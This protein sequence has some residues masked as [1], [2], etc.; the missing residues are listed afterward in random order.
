METNF[1]L[2]TVS[3]ACPMVYPGAPQK[4]LIEHIA[5]M[6]TAAPNA[7]LLLFPELSLTG[8]SCGDLFYQEKLLKSCEDAVQQLAEQSENFPGLAVAV[9]APIRVGGRIF[10]TAILISDGV[11][12]GAVPTENDLAPQFSSLG[13]G[14]FLEIEYAGQ[15]LGLGQQVFSLLWGQSRLQLGLEIG[16]DLFAISPPSARLAT[17]GAEVIGNLAAIPRLVGRHKRLLNTITDLSARLSCAYLFANAGIGE[18]STDQVYD[19]S[20]VIAENGTL[21]ADSNGNTDQVSR[22]YTSYIDVGYLRHERTRNRAFRQPNLMARPATQATQATTHFAGAALTTDIPVTEAYLEISAAR[23]ERELRPIEQK[24]FA[25][26]DVDMEERTEEV[27]GVQAAALARRIRQIHAQK[28]VLG[29]SGGLDSTLALLVCKR[30]VRLTGLDDS[31]ILA[32]MMPGFGTSKRTRQNAEALLDA[33]GIGWQEISIVPAVTQHFTDIG[34]DPNTHD[35]T[36][37]NAQARERTQIL[38]DLANKHNGLVIGTGDLSELALGW[39]TYNGDHMSMYSVNGGVPKT[40]IRAMIATSSAKAAPSNP[41]L[42]QVLQAILETPVSPELLP[43][44]H[45]GEITQQTEDHTG[46]YVLNDFFL[47]HFL[48]RGASPEK[49]LWLAEYAFAGEGGGAGADGTDGSG[50]VRNGAD[51][52][53]GEISYTSEEI[54]HWLKQF[55]KRFFTQQ[56]KRS[57]MPDGPAI[58]SIGLSPRGAWAMPSDMDGSL[59]SEGL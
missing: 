48:K 6:E 11:L 46:P 35:S 45:L 5:L 49:I 39:C 9:G 16:R 13:V 1:S 24:P 38:M 55:G 36:Y 27:L 33:L 15:S 52:G 3:I 47:Y 19:G 40:L 34:H 22:I 21:L 56:Y 42:A 23:P 25:P 54:R 14:E 32:V 8:A 41:H 29:V 4:N 12:L 28:L 18:S 58:G 30:A 37:E 26:A 10:D 20:H 53:S 51:G 2:L 59:W 50:A 43:T 57:C 7:A 31:A 17:A 44:D